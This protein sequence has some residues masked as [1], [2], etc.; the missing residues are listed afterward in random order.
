M[1]LK[2]WINL[3]LALCVL[4]FAVIYINRTKI[5]FIRKLMA[6][7]LRQKILPRMN[8]V[9][10]ILVNGYRPE[11][12]DKFILYKLKADLEGDVLK[13]DVLFEVERVTLADFLTKLST[14]I[15]RYDSDEL[16][17]K[18]AEG[19]ILTGQRLINEINEL[20]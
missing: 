15:A 16:S 1:S 14:Y 17:T 12:D 7:R 19:L 10:I 13:A 9:L 8:A 18:K 3:F 20:K 4:L 2:F 5:H 11:G 6:A